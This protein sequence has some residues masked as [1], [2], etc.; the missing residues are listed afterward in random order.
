MIRKL[1]LLVFLCALS[2]Y[3]FCE[4]KAP[5]FTVT[6][7]DD[8]SIS[9]EDV[10][11]KTVLCFYETKDTENVNAE[12]KRRIEELYNADFDYYSARLC[13]LGVAD[14]TASNIL[15]KKIWQSALIKKSNGKNYTIYGDW[16]GKMRTDFKFM[17]GN[18]NFIIIDA[19]GAI[20]FR[21]IGLI[22]NAEIDQIIDL[23]R[24]ILKE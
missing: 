6:S 11:N 18:A 7:G 13:I 17:K 3:A 8:K 22:T 4:G 12:L 14:C 23:I 24:L 15:V 10:R 21:S 9:L 16:N 20:R 1:S 19:K 5:D 2:I